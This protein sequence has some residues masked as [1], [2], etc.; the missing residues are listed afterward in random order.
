VGGALARL[1]SS[2]TGVPVVYTPNGLA[3]GRAP[4]LLER[5]LARRTAC[6]VAVSESERRRALELGVARAGRIQVVANGIDLDHRPSQ[7]PGWLRRQLALPPNA[8]VIGTIARLVPQKAPEVL[9][10]ASAA[11]AARRP[12]VHLVL[13]GS[14]P[15]R[16]DVLT[17]AV[18]LGARFHLVD[19]VDDG[20]AAIGDFDVFALSSRFEGAPYAPLEAMRA[21]VPVVLTAVVGNEDLVEDGVSGRL[22]PVDDPV[23]LARAIE[24]TL[25]PSV[26]QALAEVA[27]A[28][29][30]AL[31]VRRVGAALREV[32]AEVAASSAS[33]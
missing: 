9:V 33:R 14:G 15:L 6:F 4:L 16:D 3:T 12:D 32:Y 18:P 24:E 2:G 25:Q 23:A 19:G 28:R 8:V 22:V 29:L 31:D 5:A 20:P 11:V 13:I 17:A 1:A 7:P 27:S 21:G 26:G 10:R 30:A